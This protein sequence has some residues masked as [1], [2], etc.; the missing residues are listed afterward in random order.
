MPSDTNQAIFSE[1]LWPSA[2]IW[3][4]VIAFGAGLGLIPAPVDTTIGVITGVLGLVISVT[5]VAVTT[6]RLELTN[7]Y[8]T[9][10]RARMPVSVVA[11]VEVLDPD[12]M[13]RARGTGL[14]ARA[15]LCLRGWLPEGV[16]VILDDPEDPTPYWLLSSRRP[17]EF[18]AA[19]SARITQK[20]RRD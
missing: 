17:V 15:Y 9:A 7:G 11:A 18:A 8:L 16:K 14:D 13:R 1:R 4:A 10:G 20:P 6:P 19:V 5:F 3:A 12:Q 2:G